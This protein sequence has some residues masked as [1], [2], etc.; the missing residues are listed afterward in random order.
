MAPLFSLSKHPQNHPPSPSIRKHR[1][2]RSNFLKSFSHHHH[3]SPPRPLP[4]PSTIDNPPK[5]TLSHKL[6]LDNLFTASIKV[7]N[8]RN[9][10]RIKEDCTALPSFRSLRNKFSISLRPDGPAKRHFRRVSESVKSSSTALG[11][12]AGVAFHWLTL[13]VTDIGQD[14]P[15]SLPAPAHTTQSR[16]PTSISSN[17]ST[18]LAS[19]EQS[20][21]TQ[22]SKIPHD[23]RVIASPLKRPSLTPLLIDPPFLVPPQEVHT[24]AFGTPLEQLVFLARNDD[25]TSW[26]D[27]ACED[28]PATTPL[29]LLEAIQDEQGLGWWSSS[30]PRPSSLAQST[31]G[32]DEPVIDL[33]SPTSSSRFSTPTRRHAV[34]EDAED[35]RIQM[36]ERAANDV[37]R[38]VSPQRKGSPISARW[39]AAS[40]LGRAPGRIAPAAS[41]RAVSYGETMANARSASHTLERVRSSIESERLH[42]SHRVTPRTDF[43]RNGDTFSLGALRHTKTSSDTVQTARPAPLRSPFLESDLVS[44]RSSETGRSSSPRDTLIT[45]PLSRSGSV[46]STVTV[47]HEAVRSRHALEK[48]AL[49]K[50]LM[51]A[52]L[53]I[54]RLRED[55]SGLQTLLA[56]GM[57]EREEL[58]LSLRD[59]QDELES[60]RIELADSRFD[61]DA[62]VISM[63]TQP[64]SELTRAAPDADC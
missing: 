52:K 27:Q 29:G 54:R 44:H 3:Q 15:S 5:R 21:Y 20:P 19:S 57:V 4:F 8:D 56:E 13:L 32:V 41:G 60:V 38:R 34:D 12:L 9:N 23:R 16:A 28:T 42:S 31:F 62:A 35:E 37:T 24:S 26:V 59:V 46:M 61:G 45:T 50:A 51:S 33:G 48:D 7:T 6:S 49:L 22:A 30:K 64:S 40:A 43:A 14:L 18:E 25:C 11:E 58:R 17:V 53:E 2:T 36:L 47:P 55:N 39:R 63:N 10:Q 1:R